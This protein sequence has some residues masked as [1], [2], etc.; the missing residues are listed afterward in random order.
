MN[1]HAKKT[2]VI[3]NPTFNQW[4]VGVNV[5]F[6]VVNFETASLNHKIDRS[7]RGVVATNKGK[8]MKLCMGAFGFKIN[9]VVA[10]IWSFFIE[11]VRIC[12]VRCWDV[13]LKL[14]T[15][16][17]F[18]TWFFQC[19]DRQDM[20]AAPAPTAGSQGPIAGNPRFNQYDAKN[21][22]RKMYKLTTDIA[23][24]LYIL[25][26]TVPMFAGMPV[27]E[28]TICCILLRSNG[29][30]VAILSEVIRRQRL[31]NCRMC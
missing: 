29:E 25:L 16:P 12:I 8:L 19:F 21:A 13:F 28:S 23:R 17:F 2:W 9:V 11:L 15:R 10:T 20:R 26:Q 4:L 27:A 31:E 18:F 30:L 3:E 5:F 14:T 6:G 7:Q 24:F 1:K 22:T